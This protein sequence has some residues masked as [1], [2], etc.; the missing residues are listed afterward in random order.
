M[1]IGSIA[2][3][4]GLSEAIHPNHSGIKDMGAKAVLAKRSKKLTEIISNKN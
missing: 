1:R 3:V 4:N 2:N